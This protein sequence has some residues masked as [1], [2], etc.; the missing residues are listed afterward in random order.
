MSFRVLRSCGLPFVR[1]SGPVH[2]PVAY[3][4]LARLASRDYRL[5]EVKVSGEVTGEVTGEVRRRGGMMEQFIVLFVLA[6]VMLA[7][8][9]GVFLPL[10]RRSR[11]QRGD[12]K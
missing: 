8:S 5:A 11:R 4:D 9:V 7:I 2:D 12:D 3:N 1:H 6:G 10:A